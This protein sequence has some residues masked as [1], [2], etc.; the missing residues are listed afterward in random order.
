MDQ[1]LDVVQVISNVVWVLLAVAAVRL[2]WRSEGR[3]ARL[4]A[5][6]FV[7]A[8]SVVVTGLFLDPDSDPPLLVVKLL[9]LA[10]LGIPAALH[11]FVYALDGTGRRLRGALLAVGAAV[12]VATLALTSLPEPDEPLSTAFLLYTIAFLGLWVMWTGRAGWRLLRSARGQPSVVRRRLQLLAAGAIGLGVAL[13]LPSAADDSSIAVAVIAALAGAVA[14][15]LF[16]L[17]FAPPRLLTLWWRDPEEQALVAATAELMLAD[18]R[19]QIAEILL[20]AMVRLAGARG[21]ALRE[22]AGEIVAT[23][24]DVPADPGQR[25]AGPGDDLLRVGVAGRQEILLWT[26][27]WSPMFGGNERRLVARLAVLADLAFDR[28]M[29]LESERAAV[30]DARLARAEVE[31]F[32]ATITHDLRSPLTAIAGMAELLSG[33]LIEDVDPRSRSFVERI[34]ANTQYMSGLVDDILT[35]AEVRGGEGENVPVDLDR[36]VEDIALGIGLKT[37][38]ARVTHGGL[39]TVIG[40]PTRLRR[41]LENVVGNAVAHA[42]REDVDVRVEVLP[43]ESGWWQLAVRDNGRGIAPDQAEA[44]FAMFERGSSEQEGTGLGLPICRSAI[45]TMGGSIWFAPS[46]AGADLRIR[47][48]QTLLVRERVPQPG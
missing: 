38:Q 48:P 9:I 8:A 41:V 40:D 16:L 5:T 30:L 37:P 18:G 29:R 22:N 12:V 15:A 28:V 13:V 11:E 23:W 14:G 3:A 32:V 46:D 47:L 10:L 39:P 2:A 25:P 34:Y 7:L 26:T 31:S 17:G 24:G 45:E 21:G 27:P 19:E 33:P 44:V 43:D 42:G 4:V 6:T 36:I 1:A 35:L 20:P